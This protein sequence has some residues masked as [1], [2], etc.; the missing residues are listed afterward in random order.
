MHVLLLVVCNILPELKV[1]KILTGCSILKNFILLSGVIQTFNFA[2]NGRHLANQNYRSCIRQETGRCSVQYEPCDD[3]SFRIGPMSVSRPG[4]LGGS[5]IGSMPA[6]DA[7][8][9]DETM[10]QDE[11]NQLDENGDPINP[12][13]SDMVGAE[14]EMPAGENDELLAEETDDQ[15]ADE[16]QNDEETQDDEGSGGD[17]GGFFGGF[18][19]FSFPTFFRSFSSNFEGR[20]LGRDNFRQGRQIS[21]PCVDRITLPCIVEDF[22]GAGMG[23]IPSCIPIHCGNSFSKLE[24]AVTPFYLGVHFGDGKKNKG[25]AEDNIGAC[26]RYKQLACS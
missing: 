19:T 10:L 3:N 11:M 1:I 26:L 9:A 20:D 25:S 12:A 14:G 23:D 22:I 24:T 17:T 21:S 8:L 4:M 2:D 15:Q 7:A 16:T 6:S 5:G 13:D 18:P